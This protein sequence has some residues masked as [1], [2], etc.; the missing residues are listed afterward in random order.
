MLHFA[1]NN[2]SRIII[3]SRNQ[4]KCEAAAQKVYA[5]V[6]SF[7]GKVDVMIVNF[8]SFQSV[9]SFCDQVKKDTDR[10]DIVV[11]NAG[12]LSLKYKTTSDGWEEVLQVND[13]STGFMSLL[14]LPKLVQTGKLPV[15]EGSRDLKPHLTIVASEGE[16]WAMGEMIGTDCS[17]LLGQVCA[18]GRRGITVGSAQR[19]K[20]IR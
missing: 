4:A 20:T 18:K 16:F 2:A 10:L 15:P 14:L 19:P 3:A 13:L 6:P 7:R 1:R 8:S 17:A 9:I 5:D 11:A 12:M